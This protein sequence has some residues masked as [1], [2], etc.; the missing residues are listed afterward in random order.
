MLS[1]SELKKS[2]TFK[3]L[4][5]ASQSPNEVCKFTLR[6]ATTNI[7]VVPE[8][9]RAFKNLQSLDLSGCPLR[10]LPEWIGE[11]T[12]LQVLKICE[13]RIAALPPAMAQLIH[14][15]E[16]DASFNLDLSRGL[17]YLFS[18]KSLRKL[19]FQVIGQL[20]EGIAELDNLEEL[21]MNGLTPNH[22]LK[23]LYHL[24]KL[25]KLEICGS[26]VTALPDGIAALTNLE[27]FKLVVLPAFRLPTDF[28]ALPK[29]KEFS[30]SGLYNIYNNHYDNPAY[31]V[32]VDWAHIFGQLAQIASLQS[33]D[34]SSNCIK[35]YDAQIG[36]LTQLRK[37][38]LTDMVRRSTQDPYPTT[39]GNLKN[40]KELVISDRDLV[41]ETMKNIKQILPNV[42]LTAK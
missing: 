39:I 7:S 3:S 10:I 35:A 20:P 40:L 13:T 31:E 32:S 9:I 34:L 28:G 37:L 12:H 18:I 4:A 26:E 21:F 22:D 2:K 8:A 41:F 23:C 11:L 42:K 16:L 15:E 25:K 33:V 38:N 5:I 27:V 17:E 6:G 1:K 14:L 36:S 29:L 30:Y 24:P 19:N